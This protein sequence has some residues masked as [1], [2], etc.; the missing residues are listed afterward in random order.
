MGRRRPFN[1]FNSKISIIVAVITAV[2][3]LALVLLTQ[4]NFL[5]DLV[6][7][8]VSL[9]VRETL[10]VELDMPAL[11]GNPVMGFRG[12]DIA[13]LRA[14][15]KLLTI[16][17]LQV[18]ISLKSL[19]KNSPRVSTLLVEGLR[20][21]YASLLEMK[22]KSKENPG[23]KDVPVDKVVVNDLKISSEWGL[24]ELDESS[25]ELRGLEW[26]APAI[27]G[28]FNDTSFSL[29]GVIKKETENWVL[30]GFVARLDEGVAKVSGA[31]FPEPDFKAEIKDAN[32]KKVA[33]IFPNVSKYGVMGILSVN[34]EMSGSGKDTVTSGNGVLKKAVFGKIPLEEVAAKWR[35]E[36]GILDIALDEGKV[37]KS[38]LTG[39]LKLDTADKNR[40]MEL[41]AEACDLR[42]ADWT[43]K[44]TDEIAEEI[45]T[46]SGGITSLKADL[47]GPLNALVGSVEVAPS[48]ISYKAMK[49]TE[50]RGTAVFAGKPAG[51]VSFCGLNEGREIKLTGNVGLAAG[52]STDLKLNARSF[53]L[54][55]L[56][57]AFE[58]LEAFEPKGTADISARIVGEVGSIKVG[59]DIV[60]PAAEIKRIGK[61]TSIRVHPE[62][63]FEDGSLRVKSASLVWNGSGLSASGDMHRADGV[64]IFSFSGGIRDASLEKFYDILPFLKTQDISGAASGSWTLRGTADAPEVTLKIKVPGG[65]FRALD[66]RDFSSE[67]GYSPGLLEFDKLNA[68]LAGGS[69]SLGIKIFLPVK[70]ENGAASSPLKWEAGGK[71]KGVDLSAL[72][73]LFKAEQDMEGSCSGEIKIS[74][75]GSGV[76]WSADLSTDGARWRS[77]Y[78]DK[79]TCSLS[80]DRNEIKVKKAEADFLRGKHMLTGV[81]KTSESGGLSPDSSLDIKVTS[82]DINIYEL[83]RKHLPF[84]RGVQ[85][86]VKSE[87]KVLGTV[88]APQFKGSGT[89]SPF[90]YR[91]FFLPMVDVDFNGSLSDIYISKAKARLDRGELSGMARIF[92]EKEEWHALLD[93][94]AKDIDLRQIG[95]YLP[96]KFRDGLGGRANFRFAGKGEVSNFSGEGLLSSDRMRFLGLRIRDVSAPFWI[97][98]GYAVI[99]DVKAETN[100][101]R[102]S[103][104]LAMDIGR[105]RWGGNLTVTDAEVAPMLKQLFPGLTGSV[106]GKGDLKVRAGGEAG[107]IST[108]SAAGVLLLKDGEVSGFEAVEAAKKYTNGKPLLYKSLQAALTFDEGY[109]TI[110]PGSQAVAP[111]DDPVYRYIMLDG[112]VDTKKEMSLFAMG[113]VNIRALN[114]LL[115]ALQG[116]INVSTESSG[117]FDSSALLQNFLGGV[118]SGF[119][120]A[121]FRFVTLNVKGRVGAPEFS[122]VKV[123]KSEKITSARN[124]IP[125]SAS[126][127]NEKDYSGRESVFRLKF[128]IPVGPGVGHSH[129]S[130]EGQILEQTLGNILQGISFGN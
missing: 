31:V 124:V 78:A 9:A 80:G 27:K 84:I 40:Y 83:L 33:S 21:D 88:T 43:D 10:D 115:G 13:F 67:I 111:P 47:K 58:G 39:T 74:D 90:R 30:D 106:S 19:V 114:A 11:N 12:S 81:I 104:G 68:S 99:E 96:E 20:S 117:E 2:I 50:L 94:N 123:D 103:G 16:D 15:E 1:R 32:I 107:R 42:F 127:P 66:V 79:A 70:R 8:Q 122:N 95:A 17:K 45:S 53:R 91:G 38:S 54:E 26:Y 49:F 60:S 82:K 64:P 44:V 93:T 87:I 3:G 5:G 101:G 128:E 59:A 48:N 24:L 118:L 25:V 61:I 116:I 125:R 29:H 100:G 92:F 102:V 130:L 112:L 35:Y 108:V 18:N 4:V 36:K 7:E 97:S 62:Y 76:V 55:E 77:F 6:V 51:E 23:S 85:G 98:E 109:F 14:G 37:F 110:L 34:M 89:L 63:R 28:R 57:K 22:P 69:T 121:D 72:N 105:S 73:G 86:L 56:S 65:R 113:K 129:E 41:K 75:E 71:I 120:R 46:I 52:V 126:D 119:T